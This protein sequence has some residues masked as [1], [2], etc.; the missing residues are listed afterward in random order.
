MRRLQRLLFVAT[1]IMLG[2][3]ALPAQPAAVAQE[4]TPAADAMMME[5]ITFEPVSLALGLEA[6]NPVDVFLARITLEPGVVLPSDENDPGVGV[7]V[8]ESGAFTVQ[9][10]GPVTVT[11]AANMGDVLIAAD[12]SGDYSTVVE[13]ITAGEAVTLGAGDV[14]YI[15]ANVG[16]EIRNEGEEPAVALGFLLN[17]HGEMIGAATPAP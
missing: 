15:P 1:L 4:A 5:G 9:I 10:E 8:V 7:L 12:A 14:V 3:V 17:P 11:R 6:P 2:F 13:T 16:G